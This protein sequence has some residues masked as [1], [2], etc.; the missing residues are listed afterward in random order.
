MI[1]AV[2]DDVYSAEGVEMHME[3]DEITA[4][5]EAFMK[6]YLEAI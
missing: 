3:D 6:G 4:E 5:E 1:E 2:H